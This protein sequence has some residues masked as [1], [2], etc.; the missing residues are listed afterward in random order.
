MLNLAHIDNA[1][2]PLSRAIHEPST[3]TNLAIGLEYR[4]R[5]TVEEGI[6][7]KP[8]ATLERSSLSITASDKLNINHLHNAMESLAYSRLHSLTV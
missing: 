6:I 4:A 1:T 5:A 3:H 7:L 8:T 2:K